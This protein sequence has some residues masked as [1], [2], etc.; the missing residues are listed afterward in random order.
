MGRIVDKVLCPMHK[1]DTP[2]FVLYEDGGA[3][4]FGCGYYVKGQEPHNYEIREKERENLKE[5]IDRIMALPV[6]RI[7]GLELHYDSDSFYI[8]WDD[9]RYYKRRFF[10]ERKDK[11]RCPT[12]HDK[13]LFIAERVNGPNLLIVEG[14]LNALSIAIVTIGWTIVSPGSAAEFDKREYVEYYKQYNNIAMI[15]DHDPAG[16]AAAIKLYP[17]LIKHTPNV[18]VSMWKEDANNILQRPR[19][20]SELRKRVENEIQVE[21]QGG[22]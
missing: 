17:E 3:K 11:Y 13:P 6:A 9:S 21:V 14:E 4:C 7:R 20:I 18:K 8:V 15:V 19:G 16:A 12:G 1:E 2:S 10:E 5:S 22:L